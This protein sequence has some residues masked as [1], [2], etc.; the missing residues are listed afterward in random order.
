MRL[1]EII[2]HR[3]E[4]PLT[5]PYLLAFGNLTSFDTILVE[6]RDTDG[7]VGWGEA[8]VIEAYSGE[9]VENAWTFCRAAAEGLPG[10]ETAEARKI[11][12]AGHHDSP[13]ATTAIASAIEMLEGNPL[14]TI[15]T[16]TRVP[17]LVPVN[18]KDLDAVPG[19]VERLIGE[20][21]G[22][23]KVKV[24]FDL[25]PDLVRVAAIQK[26][27][28]GRVL[29]RLDGNQG[30]STEDGCSFASRVDPDSI[31]LLEQ[32]CA[33]GDWDAAVAM[34]QV[35]TVPM[36]LDESIF[37]PEDIDRAAELKAASF[38]KLKLMKMGGL[39]ATI[40]GLERIRGLGMEPVLGNGVATDIG[41]WMEAC[42]AARSITNA[43]EMNG[44]LKP[45]DRVLKAPLVVD[46]GDMV[47]EPGFVP[48]VDSDRV[49]AFTV[50]TER[51]A[52]VAVGT[53]AQ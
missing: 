38:I 28:A 51:Y 6:A 46:S 22:T 48:E 36:M 26:A 2:L 23:L 21:Y 33:A 12:A 15:E 34:A 1:Q 11:V 35:A 37:G 27:N 13:F 44:F 20:G 10:K 25:E 17:M 43:G 31:E 4:V 45:T 50:E 53:A 41:C 14:L 39:D 16:E 42:L 9:T 5:N 8:S 47:L 29:L 18:V 7:R 24:G 19:E 52:A 3:L 30:Y 49:A 32:P 40:D